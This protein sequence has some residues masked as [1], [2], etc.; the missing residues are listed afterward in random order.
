MAG[1]FSGNQAF[2]TPLRCVK[3]IGLM[4]APAILTAISP[5]EGFGSGTVVGVRTEGGP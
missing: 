1:N 2:A 5:G 3:S 4:L